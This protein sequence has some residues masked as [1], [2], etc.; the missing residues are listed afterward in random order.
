MAFSPSFPQKKINP[1]SWLL[2]EQ[3]A[4]RHSVWYALK[5]TYI[6]ADTEGPVS[7]QLSFPAEHFMN[8]NKTWMQSW[9]SY[10][11]RNGHGFSLS[12]WRD[13]NHVGLHCGNVLPTLSQA[14][15]I[16]DQG[17]LQATASDAVFGGL[18]S[19]LSDNRCVEE[20]SVGL[21]TT[22]RHFKR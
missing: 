9:V 18:V 21:F 19:I 15:D 22:S 12:I 7:P 10:T 8:Q 2:L 17:K 13:L 11:L 6:H 14:P 20:R 1:S 4:K 3:M 5:E 16:Y